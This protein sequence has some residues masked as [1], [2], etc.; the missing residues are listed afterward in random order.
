MFLLL[1]L[2]NHLICVVVIDKDAN[3]RP[4]APCLNS[5]AVVF[6]GKKCDWITE[7]EEDM[8]KKCNFSARLGMVY[9]L[10]PVTCA[11]VDLGPC[12]AAAGTVAD[13]ETQGEHTTLIA[14][15]RGDIETLE[16]QLEHKD[17]IIADLIA[18]NTDVEASYEATIDSLIA[19]HAL[20]IDCTDAPNDAPSSTETSPA[21]P[22]P[23]GTCPPGYS[24]YNGEC[25]KCNVGKSGTDGVTCEL[26]SAGTYNSI[27]GSTS[28]T[29]CPAN[30]FQNMVGS[31]TILDCNNCPQGKTSPNTGETM[32]DKCVN[33]PVNTYGIPMNQRAGTGPGVTRACRSCSDENRFI[34]VQVGTTT[35][36][37]TG[38]KSWLGCAFDTPADQNPDCIKIG[39][40]FYGCQDGEYGCDDWE[41]SSYGCNDQ[42]YCFPNAGDKRPN[43]T[44]LDTVFHSE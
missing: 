32:E 8:V 18:I 21:E 6:R 5:N 14:S 42:Q 27:R 43:A 28:C 41:R 16:I 19:E 2:P 23:A 29:P 34:K 1:L 3:S 9:D 31:E 11:K 40:T 22:S 20:Q 37:R 15:L 25:N 24:I 39:S 4:L 36:N 12:A 35:C 7:D 10:C 13:E 44:P 26:C 30:T 17:S 33:C 38:A